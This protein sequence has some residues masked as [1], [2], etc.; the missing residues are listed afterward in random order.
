MPPASRYVL[1]IALMVMMVSA[2]AMVAGA[3]E[4]ASAISDAPNVTHAPTTGEHAGEQGGIAEKLRHVANEPLVVLGII[5]LAAEIGGE[6]SRKFFGTPTVIGY[7]MS[8]ILIGPS[9]LG[10]VT[11]VGE[12][13]TFIKFFQLLA[14]FLLLFGVGLHANIN[15]LRSQGKAAFLTAFV[16][17]AFSFLVGFALY[18]YVMSPDGQDPQIK[19]QIALIMGAAFTPTSASIPASILQEMRKSTT[20]EAA[21]ILGAA[22]V[23]DV[24]AL[25]VLTVVASIIVSGGAVSA[26]S[27]ATA[28]FLAIG[29]GVVYT[30]VCLKLIP[31]L[32]NLSIL[33]GA[34]DLGARFALGLGFV[35]AIVG[36]V[37]FGLSPAIV[38]FLTGLATTESKGITRIKEYLEPLFNILS[39]IFFVTLGM[40]VNVNEMTSIPLTLFFVI[41]LAATLSKVIG[42]LVGAGLAGLPVHVCTRTSMGMIPRGEIASIVATLAVDSGLIG[43][44]LYGAIIGMVIF[45]SLVTPS[46]MM[47]SFEED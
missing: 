31:Y 44:D 26:G 14:V 20:L 28:S 27:I 11:P 19:L 47:K 5:L 32:T 46:L 25:V 2:C 6:V 16:N 3:D 42:T 4:D 12:V 23:D 18:W 43:L 10:L 33:I 39:P 40:S 8:G 15:T 9:F 36:E 29:F 7:M 1:L 17:A 34:E 37:I 41:V 22:V 35:G 30:L 45:T 38:A 13:A 24:L 21:T